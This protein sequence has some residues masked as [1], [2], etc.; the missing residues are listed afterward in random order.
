MGSALTYRDDLPTLAHKQQG[1]FGRQGAFS[2]QGARHDDTERSK[3]TR[4][5]PVRRAALQGIG[6]ALRQ[7]LL[8][9][10]PVPEEYWRH[11]RLL[12]GF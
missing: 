3:F 5:L 12:D 2:E 10:Q 9:L 11:G 6:R 4:R 7:R 8:P 1:A